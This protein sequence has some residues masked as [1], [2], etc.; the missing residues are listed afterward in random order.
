MQGI[1]ER[2][3]MAKRKAGRPKTSDRDDVAVKID[4]ALVGM[5][6]MVAT[7]K[8]VTLAEYISAAARGAIEK[9]FAREMERLKGGA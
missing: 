2:P 1:A 5:A 9:D 8:G 7:A 3:T 4:R 6:K